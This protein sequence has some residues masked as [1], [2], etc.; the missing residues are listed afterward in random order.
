MRLSRK[1][2]LAAVA[3]NAANVFCSPTSYC[4]TS[5]VCYQW[6]VPKATSSDSH[7]NVTYF[8]LRAHVNHTWTA[9]GTGSRMKGSD[10]FVIYADGEGNVTLSTRRGTGHVMPQYAHRD[11]VR[12]IAGSG[13]QDGL[14]I[15]NVECRGCSDLNTRGRTNWIAAWRAGEPLNSKN[16]SAAIWKHDSFNK[17]SV[18]LNRSTVSSDKGPYIFSARS[19]DGNQDAVA[20]QGRG[21][22]VAS[23]LPL[24]HGILMAVV[25][26][27]GYPA[28]SMIMPLIGNWVM[29]ASWQLVNFVAMWAGFG[30][31]L[32]CAKYAGI[33]FST[34][35]TPHTRLG[36]A[37]CALLGLQPFFGWLHHK[38]YVRHQTRGKMST[39]HVW[40]GRLLMMLGIIN[41]GL[42]LKLSGSSQAF[43]TA[44]SVVAGGVSLMYFSTMIYTRSKNK[45]NGGHD[46]HDGPKKRVNSI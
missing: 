36:V 23:N 19:I 44:Y 26:V 4:P 7:P 46:G 31:G 20:E 13:I 22:S 16:P 38:H 45:R 33:F 5:G 28:G 1:T 24:S 3:I 39:I 42:G 32:Y 30:L 11:D 21:S 41:G 27:I 43:V 35:H 8:Q 40:Y 2:A 12:L 6:A 34:P 37:V 14:M 10:M 17:F 29:H 15:A 18:D 25:F 9:L